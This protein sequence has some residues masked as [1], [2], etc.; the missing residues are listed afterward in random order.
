MFLRP[1]LALAASLCVVSCAVDRKHPTDP[2]AFLKDYDRQWLDVLKLKTTFDW[3]QDNSIETFKEMR[4]YRPVITTAPVPTKAGLKFTSTV[5]VANRTDVLEVLN[6]W[7]TFT[8]RLYGSKMDD[9][10]G[11][12]MLGRDHTRYNLVEKPYMRALMSP[13]D[14]PRIKTQVVS[15]AHKAIAE[16]T[17]TTTDPKTGKAVGRI[18]IVNKVA[19]RV[20]ILLT[21]AY[22]GFPGPDE[23]SM[24]RWSRA[25]Q[26]DFF[27][28]IKAEHGIH[29]DA[30]RAG[31]EMTSYISGLIK[32]KR[33]LLTQNPGAEDTVLARM[34]K[35]GSNE[36]KGIT[37]DR[38]II[39]TAGLLIGAGET[40][41]AAV[42]K[43]LAE[44]F[45]RPEELQ[46][47][48]KAARAN[49][50]DLLGRYV[51]EALRFRPGNSVLPRYAEQ[52]Y[53][54]AK[55]TPRETK[56]AK[57]SLVLAG[58]QSAMF[59]ETFVKNPEQ[60]RLDRPQS[61]YMILGYGHHRC[62]GDH[63]SLIQVPQIIKAL[64]LKK[65]LRPAPGKDGEID[66]KGGP[67]PEQYILEYDLD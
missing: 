22:G 59:D 63:V 54:L 13:A 9:C 60:F 66:L 28:N 23:A 15:L 20:P 67:F 57:G 46:G 21:G 30:I 44:L 7:D 65:N 10:M 43:C 24:F 34:L 32:E 42:C 31:H 16:G 8:V 50:D 64:L 11:A 53:V 56:I 41:Q 45:T 4:A 2:Q 37:D 58:T 38:M 61:M 6:N 29:A 12:F 51:W 49:N 3:L 48:I 27:K 55:G 52:D 26:A 33:A 35:E 14:Y 62:L 36:V 47:A 19:R 25:T 39:L 40:T 18:E 1:A 5:L 17:Q